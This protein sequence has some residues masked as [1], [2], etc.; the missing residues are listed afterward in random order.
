M[1]IGDIVWDTGKWICVHDVPSHHIMAVLFVCLLFLLYICFELLKLAE[2]ELLYTTH[3]LHTSLHFNFC[4]Y[5]YTFN[6]DMRPGRSLSH[7]ILWS[8][9]YWIC[10]CMYG[11]GWLT[12]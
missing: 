11:A 2:C 12:N 5:N 6:R 1:N 3:T 4:R 9:V 8:I 7:I 10:R